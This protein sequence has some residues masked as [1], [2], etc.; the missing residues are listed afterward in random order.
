[1]D[2][3]QSF[4]A[5]SFALKA[6]GIHAKCVH[7][8]LRAGERERQDILSDGSTAT[9]IGVCANAHELM[10]WAKRTN[11]RILLNGYVAGECGGIR[12]N[13]VVRNAAIVRNV[14][15]R[16]NEAIASDS[17]NAASTGSP[18]VDRHAFA[19]HIVVPDFKARLF[20][21]EFQILRFES[22]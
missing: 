12:H 16:H 3:A 9:D 1:M 17:G 4:S 22:E 20:A 14:R 10:Y 2:F 6:N 11:H 21:F 5:K 15:V 7:F 18:A 8:A 13:D 19:N